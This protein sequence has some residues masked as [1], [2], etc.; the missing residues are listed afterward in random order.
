MAITKHEFVAD[1][2]KLGFM[3]LRRDWVSV[4]GSVFHSLAAANGTTAEEEKAKLVKTIED[5]ERDSM[6]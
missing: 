4:E 3:V 2:T 6:K 1:Y 5:A